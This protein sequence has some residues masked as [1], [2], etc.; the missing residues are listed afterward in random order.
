MSPFFIKTKRSTATAPPLGAL[1]Q[2]FSFALVNRHLPKLR[3]VHAG[4]LIAHA[5]KAE[6]D[7]H[8]VR[9][10][11]EAELGRHV[12]E[13]L[14][15][16]FLNVVAKGVLDRQALRRTSGQKGWAVRGGERGERGAPRAW[17]S[18]R[19]S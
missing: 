9:R 18:R 3:I 13:R 11:R 2:V 6:G 12:D 10:A 15:V 14:H 7:E 17:R 8:V 1:A 16:R 4:Q 19:R 5:A